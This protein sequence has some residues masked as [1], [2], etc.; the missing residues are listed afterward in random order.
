MVVGGGYI[1]V[2][3]ASIFNGLGVQTTLLYRGANILRGFDDDVRAHLADELEKRGIKV[4]LGCSH[5]RL[6][7]TETG[8]LS[9][10][11]NELT[12]ETDLVMFAT[13]REAY[14]EGLGLDKAGV[15]LN[16]RGA[17]AVDD[18]SKTNVDNIWAVG[19]VTDRINLTPVAIREGAAFAQT[20]FHDNPTR[21]DHDMVASAVFSQPPV[22]VV[23][24]TEAQA[25]HAFGKVDIY[26]AVF[27]PMKVT[28]YGGQDR[29]LIK[30]VVKQDDERIVGV[31]IVGPDSPEII[32]MAAVAV[33]MGVTK[34]QWDSTC[35]VHP[36]LAEELVTLREKYM[37]SEMSA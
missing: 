11:N 14:V 37:P 35:A 12:F 13:G 36:T 15:A 9:T 8:L 1:A 17:I 21:F 16:E 10:L 4:V 34:A 3:F 7:Q 23:G 28:F 18:F 19:D 33:K 25:R 24:M 31:H 30:L 29:C 26:R 2:E 20:E 27:R 22:G 6:E 32:Q 5:E